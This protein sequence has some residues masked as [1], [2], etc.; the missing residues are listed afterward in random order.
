MARNTFLLCQQN[1]QRIIYA[2]DQNEFGC[3]DLALDPKR[4]IMASFGAQSKR[5]CS[6]KNW[7][8]T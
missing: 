5:L 7:V 4:G 6:L 2:C 8:M 1:V 3:E